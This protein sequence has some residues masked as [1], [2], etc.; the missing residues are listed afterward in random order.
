[1]RRTGTTPGTDEP[2]FP[3]F[4][5]LN[6]RR[7]WDDATAGVVLSRLAL[8]DPARFHN[9][10]EEGIARAL[11]DQLLD[12][13][14]DPR[15]PVFEMIDARLAAGQTDGWHYEDLP[16][17]ATAWKKS[18]AALDADARDRCGHGFAEADRH[19]QGALI[20]AVQD[21]SQDHWHGMRADHLWSLWTRYACTAFYAHPWSWNEIGF[22][23]PAYPRG[24][25][26]AGIDRREAY[27]VRDTHPRDPTEASP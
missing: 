13:H 10:T 22:S 2:H 16:E 27:E 1:M 19:D 12:Q 24:Y 8:P 25:K 20:Q 3:G 26:N 11:L 4:D 21:R 17:D 15:V 6:Q 14:D 23:G 9:L 5:V 18:L 7:H